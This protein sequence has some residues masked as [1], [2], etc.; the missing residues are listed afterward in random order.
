MDQAPDNTPTSSLRV[1]YYFLVAI[2]PILFLCCSGARLNGTKFV[3]GLAACF[4]S[5][6]LTFIG[7]MSAIIVSA[8]R[9]SSG[10]LWLATGFSALTGIAIWIAIRASRGPF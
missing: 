1:A 6:T 3:L 9:G 10:G 7:F 5:P 4:L 8:R 2:P